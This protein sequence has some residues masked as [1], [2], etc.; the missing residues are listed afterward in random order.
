[1]IS[2][3][4]SRVLFVCFATAGSFQIALAAANRLFNIL[5]FIQL[6]DHLFGSRISANISVNDFLYR[7]LFPR[8]NLGIASMG[9]GCKNIKDDD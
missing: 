9:R 2:S 3:R 4:P 1:V 8:H 5:G 6:P 7:T